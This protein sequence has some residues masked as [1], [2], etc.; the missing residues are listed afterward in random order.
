MSL[1]LEDVEHIAALARLALSDSEKERFRQQLSSILEYA[2]RLQKVDTSGISPTSR[3]FGRET[4]KRADNPQ[5]S[6]PI[7]ILMRNAPRVIG[8]QFLLPPVME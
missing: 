2:D 1:T 6:L 3:V 4:V 7:E 5:P 8:R